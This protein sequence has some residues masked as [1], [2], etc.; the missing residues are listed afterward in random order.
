VTLAT[1]NTNADVVA[2]AAP[3]PATFVFPVAVSVGDGLILA[4]HEV[5]SKASTINATDIVG[6]VNAAGWALKSGPTDHSGT[7]MR[8]WVFTKVSTGAGTETVTITRTGTPNGCHAGAVITTDS[9]AITFG[10]AAT[11]RETG[12]TTDCDTNTL[13]AAN[14]GGVMGVIFTQGDQS[15]VADG[16]GETDV[17][18]ETARIHLVWEPYASGGTKGIEATA[19]GTSANVMHLI[20]VIEGDVGPAPPTITDVDEDNTVT[21][22]Q[23]NVEIDG[24]DFDDNVVEV[25]QGGFDYVPSVD[26]ASA[27]AIVFDMIAV[28]ATGPVSA[29]H[30]GAATV[31]VIN[32]DLQEDTQAITISNRSGANTLLIGT[33]NAD[34]GLRL[35]STADAVAGDFVMWFNVQ[36]GVIGDVTVNDDLTFDVAEAVTAFDFQIW[37]S[38]DGTWGD[39]ATQTIGE[40]EPEPEPEASGV[41]P[42]GSNRRRRRYYVEVDGQSFPVSSRAEAEQILQR[43]RALAERDAESQGDAAVKKLAKKA[44]VPVVDIP[45]PVLKVSP[46]LDLGPLVADIERLYK[47]AAE[48]AELRLRMALAIRAQ[49][50]EDEDELLL[51]L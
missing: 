26:S 28:G 21:L 4:V 25:R 46:E 38:G 22:E 3:M 8:T 43:A 16:A 36:G 47:R 48:N 27:T 50:Q 1:S 44:A 41:T 24:T 23:A 10:A 7:T 2:A 19:G 9:G 13:V 30:A 51:L 12:P 35:D 11:T 14:P 37:D 20:E 18:D 15:M 34:A 40:D 6:S 31:A 49:E 17:T 32:A 39:A 33:P 5:G 42:A 45:P 29:P